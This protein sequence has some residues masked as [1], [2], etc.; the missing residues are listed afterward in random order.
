[1][2][3]PSVELRGKHLH[4]GRTE[5]APGSLST[6]QITCLIRGWK[7]VIALGTRLSLI[8]IMA[9]RDPQH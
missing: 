8:K 6:F 9:I 7:T 2:K 5:P 1:M 4:Q 3:D